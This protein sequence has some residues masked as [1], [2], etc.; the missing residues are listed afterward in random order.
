MQIRFACLSAMESIIFIP[1]KYP[2]FVVPRPADV[3]TT[4]TPR[5]WFV[6]GVYLGNAPAVQKAERADTRKSE[7]VHTNPRTVRLTRMGYRGHSPHVDQVLSQGHGIV[8]ARDRYGPVRARAPLT[9][10]AV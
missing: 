6:N 3:R 5:T 2:I 8:V 7:S 10:L 4:E 9:V 1:T